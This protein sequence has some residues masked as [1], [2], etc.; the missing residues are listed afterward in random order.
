[1]DNRLIISSKPLLID[2]QNYQQ[3]HSVIHGYRLTDDYEPKTGIHHGQF[4]LVIESPI[5]RTDGDLSIALKKSYSL[6]KTITLILKCILGEAVN[7][8]SSYF[9][10]FTM[11][12]ISFK[13]LPQGWTSNRDAVQKDLDKA[14]RFIVNVEPVFEHYV[15]MSS[16]PFEDIVKAVKNYPKLS[17][18]LKELLVLINEAD[19]VTKNSRYLLLG[20]ALEIVNSLYPYN[21]SRKDNRINYV[22]PD[23]EAIF[24][25]ISL[26][27]LLEW[28]NT[29]QEA[30]HYVNKRQTP[31]PKMTDDERK[32]YYECTNIFCIN[33]IRKAL[34]LDIVAFTR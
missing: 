13:D 6:A 7:T 23:L 16:S 2:I 8:S 9:Q 30:R 29:R 26:K 5:I 31:H 4:R 34:G 21:H 33:V 10:S 17:H 20:K 18:S 12:A 28:A 1:M 32:R 3:G 14:K 19:L 25:G 15:E 11:Q 24:D 27:K 22:F